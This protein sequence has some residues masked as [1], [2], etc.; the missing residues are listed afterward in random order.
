MTSN[1]TVLATD[2]MFGPSDWPAVLLWPLLT[3]ADPSESLTRLVVLT[4]QICR[5]P[6]GKI[7]RRPSTSAAFTTLSL[8]GYGLYPVTWTRP[9]IAASYAVRIPRIGVLPPAS[10]RPHLAVDALAIG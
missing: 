7:N 3:S 8:D 2:Y 9:D 5:S 4:G 10:F 6:P 1:P